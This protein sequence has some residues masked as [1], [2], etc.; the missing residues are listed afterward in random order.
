M[1]RSSS[2]PTHPLCWSAWYSSLTRVS[3]AA[4]AAHGHA[5]TSVTTRA[6]PKARRRDFKPRAYPNLDS[7]GAVP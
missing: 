7:H 2:S 3:I 6:A 1:R 5:I 4:F